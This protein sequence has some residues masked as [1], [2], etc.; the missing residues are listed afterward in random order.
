M[1]KRTLLSF[2]KSLQ[3]VKLQIGKITKD[4][5][6]PF[7]KSKYFDINKLLEVVEPL[8]AE[9]D[10]LLMQPVRNGKVRSIIYDLTNEENEEYSE[11]ELTQ[12]ADPQ[13]TGSAITYFRRYTLS[14]LLSIQSEDDDANKA[15]NKIEKDRRAEKRDLTLKEVTSIWNGKIYQ[16]KYVYINDVKLAVSPEQLTK[17]K[18]HDKFIK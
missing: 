7:H 2:R 9:N 10:M 17:L 11:I 16:D 18:N 4:V 3:V 12:N 13:K 8:L 6:N 1:E 5:E 14:G 15:G